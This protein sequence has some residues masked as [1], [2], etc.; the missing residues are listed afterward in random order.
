MQLTGEAI[1]KALKQKKCSADLVEWVWEHGDLVQQ[2]C[3]LFSQVRSAET[4]IRFRTSRH[5]AIVSEIAIHDEPAY[6]AWASELGFEVPAERELGDDG[7]ELGIRWHIDIWNESIIDAMW[8]RHDALVK[9]NADSQVLRVI[10]ALGH[11]ILEYHKNGMHN[12][13]DG[14]LEADAELSRAWV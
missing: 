4:M 14:H 5:L 8:S 3:F 6:L 2:A 13:G 9:E 12:W 10:K 7:E 1:E 11:L